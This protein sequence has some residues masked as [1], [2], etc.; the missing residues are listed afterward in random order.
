MSLHHLSWLLA[1]WVVTPGD[2]NCDTCLLRAKAHHVLAEA[3]VWI[4]YRAQLGLVVG[5][6]DLSCRAVDSD[7]WSRT[8]SGLRNLRVAPGTYTVQGIQTPT[9]RFA[10]HFR[11]YYPCLSEPSALRPVV[12]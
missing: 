10:P 12:V 4:L 5:P 6:G 1:R 2:E 7:L 3:G 8:H 11:Q 9:G